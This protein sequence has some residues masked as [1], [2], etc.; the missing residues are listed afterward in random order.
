MSAINQSPH[1]SI[2]AD[3]GASSKATEAPITQEKKTFRESWPEWMR[4][5]PQI[6]FPE[7]PNENFELINPEQLERIIASTKASPEAIAQLRS[8]LA[9]LDKE[10]LRL[11]RQRDFDAKYQQNRYRFYQI[12]YMVSLNSAP[13]WVPF[14]GFLETIIAVMTTFLATVSANEPALPLWL[15]NRRKAEQMRREYFRFLM[16]LAPYDG[17]DNY[18]RRRKLSVRVA[19]INRGLADANV[20][21]PSVYAGSGVAASD[22]DPTTATR[23]ATSEQSRIDST[24]AVN[25]AAITS[26]E[27]AAS[28]PTVTETPLNPNDPTTAG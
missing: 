12:A 17:L 8:D 18:D 7:N 22:A 26:P 24:H 10:L 2:S 11:F 14:L 25:N 15:E 27:I 19:N 3:S 1:A 5:L 28:Q 9:F 23:T 21:P 16:D 6:Q 13:D 20:E 4:Q